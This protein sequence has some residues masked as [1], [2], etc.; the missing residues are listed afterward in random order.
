MNMNTR[1]TRI[2]TAA[3]AGLVA[4][5]ALTGLST[6]AAAATP[7]KAKA[8]K[9]VTCTPANT[10]T[11]LSTVSRPINHVLIKTTNKGKTPCYAYG[12]PLIGFDHPQA[13]V[14]TLDES[15][16]Q[17]VVT[18]KPG[19]SA[20]AGVRTS[21]GDGAEGGHWAKE[22]SLNFQGRD[23]AGSVGSTAFPAV[24][25]KTWVDDSAAVTWWQ[26]TAADA[27]VW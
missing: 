23:M 12:T 10:K 19:Q 16:P 26:A 4:V 6:S 13:A 2:T 7:A 8:A 14:W 20:Y 17:A 9:T 18:L 22:M 21:A 25:K 1:R 3:A 11:T 27:L 15:R 24:P 5:L